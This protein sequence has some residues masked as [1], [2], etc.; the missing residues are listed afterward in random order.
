MFVITGASGHVGS[1]AAEALL[2]AGKKVRVVVRDVAKGERW[3]ARG[4]EVVVADLTDSAAFARAV[5]SVDGVFLLSP[6]DLGAKNFIV[7]RKRQTGQQVDALVAEKVPHV[8]LLSSTGAQYA[9]GTGPIVTTHNAEQQL[10]ASGLAATFVRAGYFV[11]NWGT[12]VPAVRSDGILPSF[13]PADRRIAAVSTPDIGHEVAQS[14]LEG[15]RGVRTIELS[16]PSD[17]SPSDVAAALSRILGKPVKVME[18]PL[19]AVVP[20]LTSFGI[21][22]NLAGLFRELYAGLANGKIVAEPGEHV[23]GTTPLETTLRTLLG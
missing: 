19:D 21:S 10:R 8:V 6:P 20:T 3:K 23:R 17:V 7:D 11:E 22:E 2:A 15:P 12:V 4:C 14:L 13:I 1:V 5:R 16:G 18:A 9:S